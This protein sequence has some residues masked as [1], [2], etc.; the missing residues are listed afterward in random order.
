[1]WGTAMRRFFAGIAACLV[2]AAT[3][4]STS[5]DVPVSAFSR[6]PKLDSVAISPDG[7]HVAL[8]Q[9]QDGQ[10]LF[11]VYEVTPGEKLIA[12]YVSKSEKLSVLWVAWV[13]P[14]RIL[15][16]LGFAARRYGIPTYETRLLAIDYDGSNPRDMVKQ[17]RDEV[18]I[19]IQDGVV[20]LLPHD[21]DHILMA[22]NNEDPSRPR[23]YKVD[24][25]SGRDTLVQSGQEGVFNW[26]TDQRG[27]V[28]LGT[29]IKDNA[30][31]VIIR[32]AYDTT[33]R[34]LKKSYALDRSTFS[35]FGFAKDPNLLYV[36]SN[37]EGGFDALYEFD[38]TTDQFTKRIFQAPGVD[39]S[40]LTFDA[41][42]ERP[43]SVSYVTEGTHR[44]WLDPAAEKDM[45]DLETALPGMSVYIVDSTPDGQAHIVYAQSV[46]KSGGYYYFHR[47]K[48]T[49]TFLGAIYPELE[50]VKLS[51]MHSFSYKARDGLTIPAYLSL[52]PNV[53]SPEEASKLPLIVMPHG[54]PTARDHLAFDPFVQ[55]LTSRGYAV[56]QMNFRGSSGFGASFEAAG[57]G[58]WGGKMQDD[59]TD[60]AQHLIAAGIADPH[61]ICIFGISYGGYAA[62]MGAVV[63]P[64]FYRCAVSLNGATDLRRLIRSRFN[65][66]G[67]RSQLRTAHIGN[68][69]DDREMLREAS[70]KLRA[71]E[72]TIPVLIAAADDD[73]V[74]EREQS[75]S[76]ASALRAAGANYKFLELENGGHSLETTESRT[77]FMSE[78]VS[79]LAENLD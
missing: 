44:Y 76:M 39:V 69:Y 33:W 30:W 25:N 27:E 11:A 53:A 28:R 61:R 70:P 79:F 56:L 22:Y 42:G 65:Y 68:Y 72:I 10:Y 34:P 3:A 67:G 59:V 24:V 18:Q 14:T 49:L 60:G 4:F 36:A 50:G 35:F 13:N 41:K 71:G 17:R 66:I 52:P 26:Y 40:G 15:V 32:G 19:Q 7:K 74:V 16:S 5:A 9:D 78:L 21:P 8:Q 46:T 38:T 37:H 48:R 23:V 58:E 73:R 63:T 12:K 77:A 2:Y 62:L 47:T 55:L 43:I 1:M 64:E 20:D 6:M 57:Y 31:Q 75:S 51:P 29:G 54:G 45:K